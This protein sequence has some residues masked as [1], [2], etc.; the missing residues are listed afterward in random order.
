VWGAREWGR[1][2]RRRRLGGLR[3][4]G[5]RGAPGTSTSGRGLWLSFA[6]PS[7]QVRLPLLLQESVAAPISGRREWRC[8]MPGRLPRDMT[9]MPGFSIR[10]PSCCRLSIW[11]AT[12]LVSSEPPKRLA[13]TIRFLNPSSSL[14]PWNCWCVSQD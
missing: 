4:G 6:A 14:S 9:R 11:L 2:R 3:G 10:V 1:C 5:S 8:C 7:P 12:L 13:S